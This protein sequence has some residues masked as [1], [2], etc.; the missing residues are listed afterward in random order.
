M[1]VDVL[2]LQGKW[3]NSQSSFAIQAA[4]DR[5]LD[6]GHDIHFPPD[7][8]GSAMI[9]RARNQSLQAMRQKSD[10]VLFV[11]DDMV[12]VQGALVR[13]V[14]HNLPVVSALCTTR[15]IPPK[16][17][18]K[19]YDRATDTFSL[20]ENFADNMLAEGPWAVGF[21][22]VLIRRDVLD[23]VLEYVLSGNDWLDL[24][25]KHLDRLCVRAEN[26]EKERARIEERRRALWKNERIAPIFQMPLHDEL[27][28][29]IAEDMHFSRLL[30]ALSIKVWVDTGCL[31]GHIGDFPYSPLQLGV[32][33]GSQVHLS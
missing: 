31:V 10:F 25:R 12:P 28:H 9:T 7:V 11:D 14:D 2:K 17:A 30:H 23:Q 26:R 4:V 19:H 18:L 1:R 5:A 32:T 6:R 20:V 13:L 22:F 24:N 3:V 21:G 8:F 29:E 15:S 16:I 27:Q 33:H